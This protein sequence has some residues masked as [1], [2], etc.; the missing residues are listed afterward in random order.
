MV[1]PV[2]LYL[3]AGLAD[4]TVIVGDFRQLSPVCVAETPA[5]REWLQRD[6]FEAVGIPDDVERGECPDHVVML[7]E[8][9]R[10]APAIAELVAGAYEGA[11][12]TPT[13]DHA[14]NV[15][16]LGRHALYYVDAGHVPSRV[17]ISNWGSRRNPVHAELIDRL[18]TRL[19]E[20]GKL[21]HA[22]L[23]GVLC[24]TP[25]VDQARLLEATMRARFGRARPS[26]RTIHRSQGREAE[27]VVVDL[28]DAWNAPLSRFMAAPGVAAPGGRLLT[29]ALTRARRHLV[30]VGDLEHLARSA[31][32]GAVGRR[33]VQ[34]LQR[35]GRE[36]PPGWIF[37]DGLAA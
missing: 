31:R 5:A 32:A 13:L 9:Y 12:V 3:A 33:L 26:V 1:S 15:G 4:R 27:V 22:D 25:F 30:V 37:G 19:V 17:E 18:L 7:R 28:V 14:S 23:P 24:I 20:E 34:D 2:V 29:V 16:P 11:L 21:D 35:L 10:M 36:I 6:P 8:Q